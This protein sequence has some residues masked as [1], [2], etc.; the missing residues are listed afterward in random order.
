MADFATRRTIMV[1]T[2][3]RPS[4][5]TEYP[6]IQAML[7]IPRETYVPDALRAV[8]YAEQNVPLPG[9]GVI[10]APRTFAKMLEAANIAA[11]DVVLDLGCGLG[12]ST[13]VLAHMAQAVVALEANPELA[14]EAQQILSG[15]GVDNAA[16][17]CAPLTEGA[18]GSGPYDVIICQ[19]AL[20]HW[21]DALNDQLREGGRALAL[22]SEGT[23]CRAKVGLKQGGRLIWRDLFAASA[24]VLDGFA[25]S[26]EF[27]L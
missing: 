14:E 8:A 4:D 3:V 6:I 12:Y 16:V 26:R 15:E 13:A 19:G 18:A 23:L 7:T 27:A 10:L 1:D 5:V 9:G 24:P 2:Q 25:R 17:I 21:P 11:S 22:W 20:E